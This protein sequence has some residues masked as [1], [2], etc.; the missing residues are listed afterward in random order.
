MGIRFKY[1]LGAKH[2]EVFITETVRKKINETRAVKKK[3]SFDT[4]SE[5]HTTFL[6]WT[7]TTFSIQVYM[8]FCFHE[9]I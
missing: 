7:L 1:Q 6:R 9:W 5:I 4:F 8:K 2:V 3:K